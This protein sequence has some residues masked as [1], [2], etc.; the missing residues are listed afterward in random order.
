MREK[1]ASSVGVK[2][3]NLSFIEKMKAD[4]ADVQRLKTRGPQI[5]VKCNYRVC[6]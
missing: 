1:V 4:C 2:Q 6:L 5:L 3:S